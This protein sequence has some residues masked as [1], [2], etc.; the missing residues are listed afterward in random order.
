LCKPTS[1]PTK[2][3]T[4]DRPSPL[5]RAYCLA[6]VRLLQHL[7]DPQASRWIRGQPVHGASVRSRGPSP[8]PLDRKGRRDGDGVGGP[9]S[10]LV[11]GRSPWTADSADD[12]WRCCP[13]LRECD[14]EEL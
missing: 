14:D 5:H 11:E 1:K 7:H 2:R 6:S 12:A 13:L 8:R 10:R 9:V 4:R 3:R